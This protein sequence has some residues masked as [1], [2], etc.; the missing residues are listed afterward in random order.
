METGEGSVIT[1]ALAAATVA[2]AGVDLVRMGVPN[3]ASWASPL[4]AVLL[5]I[6]SVVLLMLA[7]GLA[8]TA[9]LG[10]T[11]VLAGILAAGSAVGVT[12][13]GKRTRTGA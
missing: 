10:A 11:A 5:G 2:K 1:W 4:L 8:L 7:A 6:S 13:L 3:L 12:E 9:Q